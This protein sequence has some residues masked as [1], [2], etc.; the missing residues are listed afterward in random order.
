VLF[1]THLVAAALLGRRVRLSTGW[2]VV[3]AALPD[4]IDKPL[5]MIGL[6]DLFHTVGHSAL[7]GVVCVPLAIRH[8]PGLTV[9]VGW[10]SHLLLDGVHVVVNGRPADALFLVWPLAVPPDPLALGIVPFVW[11]YLWTPSFFLESLV[12]AAFVTVLLSARAG[13]S[14]GPAQRR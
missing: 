5:A 7:L 1:P 10:A 8:R 14:D 2:L 6:V 11:Q 9:A 3:G 13:R 12:W 4:V